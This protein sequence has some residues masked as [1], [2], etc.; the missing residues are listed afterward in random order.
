MYIYIYRDPW[1]IVGHPPLEDHA[2]PCFGFESLPE[3]NANRGVTEYRLAVEDR[4]SKTSRL[5]G[6]IKKSWVCLK[7]G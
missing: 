2:S 3:S 6:S 5:D 7:M 1:K 4:R